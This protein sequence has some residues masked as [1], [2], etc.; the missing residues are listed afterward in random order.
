MTAE[1]RLHWKQFV[2]KNLSFVKRISAN[3]KMSAEM[4][5][6][7]QICRYCLVSVDA[8]N[9]ADCLRNIFARA[10][11]S[12]DQNLSYIIETCIEAKVSSNCVRLR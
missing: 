6:F 3:A 12:A 8:D 11:D 9:V 4:E 10:E 5:Y 1:L 2:N 7:Q